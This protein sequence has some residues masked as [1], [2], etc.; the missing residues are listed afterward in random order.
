[1]KNQIGREHL[2]AATFGFK[3]AELFEIA[4]EVEREAP[5]VDLSRN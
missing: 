1:M 4:N 2:F 3:N 5:V